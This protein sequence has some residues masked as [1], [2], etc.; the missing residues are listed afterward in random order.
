MHLAVVSPCLLR[1]FAMTVSQKNPPGIQTMFVHVYIH[2]YH[3]YDRCSASEGEY[4]WH[5]WSSVCSLLYPSLLAALKTASILNLVFLSH[6]CFETIIYS[7]TLH[8]F[9]LNL[10]FTGYSWFTVLSQFLLYSKVSNVLLRQR[11]KVSFTFCMKWKNQKKSKLTFWDGATPG[12]LEII[13]ENCFFA[14]PMKP[15]II[16]LGLYLWTSEYSIQ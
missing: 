11:A 4:W 14:L 2:L 5:D 1:L 12:K 13:Q 7:I 8:I 16:F 6:A 10:F 15:D 3:Q 9:K